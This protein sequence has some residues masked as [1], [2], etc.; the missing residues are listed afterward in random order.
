MSS[1]R[2]RVSRSGWHEV[3]ARARQLGN[4]KRHGQKAITEA[5]KKLIEK[6]IEKHGVTKCPPMTFS[7]HLPP[8]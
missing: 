2:H 4:Q 7:D 6:H 5:D 8:M 1:V 3:A